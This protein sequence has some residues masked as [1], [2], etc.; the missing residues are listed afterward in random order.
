MLHLGHKIKGR[1]SSILKGR[2]M[3]GKNSVLASFW[4]LIDVQTPIGSN[5]MASGNMCPVSDREL[6]YSEMN[7]DLCCT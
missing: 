5:V 2:C 3:V 7:S 6:A 1:C 4:C